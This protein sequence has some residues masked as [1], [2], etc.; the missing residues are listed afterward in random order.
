MAPGA[1]PLDDL[2]S[3]V[4]SLAEVKGVHLPGLVRDLRLSEIDPVDRPSVFEPHGFDGLV[5]GVFE[6]VEA[7]RPGREIEAEAGQAGARDAG[8]VPVAEAADGIGAAA[9]ADL[10]EEI[11]GAWTFLGHGQH[12]VREILEGDIVGDDVLVDVLVELCPGG[13]FGV[14]QDAVFEHEN[15]GV[16]EYAALG[17]EEEGIRALTWGELLDVVRAH[18]MH[19]A[20]TILAGEPDQAAVE[21]EVRGARSECFVSV[22]WYLQFMIHEILRVG[23]L[24]CNCSIFGD[25][26]TREAIVVDPGDDIGDIVAILEKRQLTVKA[27]VIT[28]AHIDHI[29]GAAKLKALT[30]APVWMNAA[31]QELYDHLEMQAGW[32][33]VETPESTAIDQNARD[34]DALQLNGTEFHILHTPGHTPGSLSIWIPAVGKLVAGDTLFRDSI[35]R[36]D[37]PGGDGR[38]I[39]RSIRDKLLGLPG[40]TVVFPGHGESTTIAREKARNPFLQGM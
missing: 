28:H 40:E 35:G 7:E 10:G 19:Q 33:G 24:Q 8:D 30:G 18:G 11:R 36:T 13:A 14:D 6:I 12:A 23:P 26:T 21:R 29:G 17:I 27:I 16:G 9:E 22:H 39:L 5:A 15:V 3:Q 4:A 34:G 20:H 38:K 2:L 25:E 31:D 32:L 1:H 37:L